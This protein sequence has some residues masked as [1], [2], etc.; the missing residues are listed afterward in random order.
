M[1]ADLKEGNTCVDWIYW[2]YN[3]RKWWTLS[4]TVM[5]FGF[6]TVMGNTFPSEGALE[7]ST[8]T[9]YHVGC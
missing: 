8:R 7:F 4:N 5:N 3:T 9:P 1:K 2:A 6:H